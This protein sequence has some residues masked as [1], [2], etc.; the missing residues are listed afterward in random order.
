MLTA[1][2]KAQPAA[3]QEC[4]LPS[5]GAMRGLVFGLVLVIPFWAFVWAL[6]HYL[7]SAR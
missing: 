1:T 4:P 2:V 7:R 3:K 6:I 5:V